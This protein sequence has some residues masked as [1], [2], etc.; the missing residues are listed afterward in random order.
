MHEAARAHEGD[1]RRELR[2]F[3]DIVGHKYCRPAFGGLLTQQLPQLFGSHSV[4]AGKGLVQE[5]Y[6]RVMDQ[7]TRDGGSLYQATRQLADAAMLVILQPEANQ[8][9][10]LADEE[11]TLRYVVQ[12][13][14]KTQILADG[15]RPVQLRLV[16]DPTD[17]AASAVD[18]RA[19]AL[20]LDETSENLEE[21][22]LAGAVRTEH[23]KRLAGLDAER[24][25]VEGPDR[26]EAVP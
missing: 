9:T 1:V 8:E 6:A 20:R 19:P 15:Q 26:T 7:R 3:F 18:L 5:Q 11:L 17:G 4:Q 12:R 24:N 21:G 16:P 25:V 23:R 13:R 10:V 14:P 22:G 2:P